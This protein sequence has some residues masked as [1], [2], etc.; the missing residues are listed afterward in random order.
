MGPAFSPGAAPPRACA[1]VRGLLSL[2]SKRT[3]FA[4]F[5]NGYVVYTAVVDGTV[6]SLESFMIS[7]AICRRRSASL[8]F[9]RSCAVVSSCRRRPSIIVLVPPGLRAPPSD[10][11]LGSRVSFPM[12]CVQKVPLTCATP[13]RIRNRC[14]AGMASSAHA[15]HSARSLVSHSG[16]I[17][18]GVPI[19]RTPSSPR[20]RGR[21]EA[22]VRRTPLDANGVVEPH[23]ACSNLY[24]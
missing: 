20:R 21:G 15:S 14:I 2:T 9:H 6:L 16:V 13:E 11:P 5:V 12:G 7:F 17:A 1:G 23:C 4:A 24:Q 22:G 10:G 18:G 19:E 3:S 8:Q